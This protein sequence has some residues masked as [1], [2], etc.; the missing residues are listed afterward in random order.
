MVQISDIHSGSFTNKSAVQKGVEKILQLK[1]DL[2]L[3]TGDLV[4]N[5]SDEMDDYMDL[6]SQL[7]APMGV[8]STR[9]PRLRGLCTMA[10]QGSKEEDLEHL[11]QIHGQLGW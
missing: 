10:E 3:F 6:F 1:P 11:K 5:K 9:K 7:K 8:F 4:N 2:V